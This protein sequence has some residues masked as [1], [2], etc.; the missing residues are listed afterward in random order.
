[1]INRFFLFPNPFTDKIN[2]T[3]KRN[4]LVEVSLYDVTSRKIVNQSFTNSTSINTEQ[5]SKGIYIYEVRNKNGVIK[6]GKVVKD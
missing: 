2:I 3:V 4:E 1:M 6:K 5:L